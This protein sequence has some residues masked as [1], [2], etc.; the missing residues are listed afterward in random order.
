[1]RGDQRGSESVPCIDNGDGGLKAA[2]RAAK[3]LERAGVPECRGELADPRLDVRIHGFG[4]LRGGRI[5]PVIGGGERYKTIGGRF[6]F[7]LSYPHSAVVGIEA[8]ADKYSGAV[9]RREYEVY[10]RLI[11]VPM[12]YDPEARTYT[13]I[14]DGTFKQA[15]TDNG[16]WVVYDL[17]KDDRFGL[18]GDIAP[19][20]IEQ[21]KWELYAIAVFN[22]AL[23]DN[24]AGSTEPRYRF[25]GVIGRAEAAAKVIAG[26]LSNFRA[27]HYYGAGAITPFQDASEDPVALVGPANVEDGAFEYG[28]ATGHSRRYSAVAVS[29]SDPADGYRLGIELV[30]DDELVAE[31]G[32]R[33]KDVAALYCTHRS[34]AHR[35]GRHILVE[36]EHEAGTLGYTA[37]LDHAS[38]WPGAI[39]RVAD[40]DRVADRTACRVVSLDRVVVRTTETET[41]YRLARSEPSAPGGGRR[42]ANHV[43]AGWQVAEPEPTATESV[44]SVTRTVT[45]EN[46]AFAS[47]TGWGGVTEEASPLL[48]APDTVTSGGALIWSDAASGLGDLS[49]LAVSGS[50]HLTYLEIDNYVRLRTV[51]APGGSDTA[52]GPEL[53]A[54]WESAADAITIQVDG[55]ED[56]VL[57]GPNRAGNLITDATE[58]YFWY[59]SDANVAYTRVVTCFSGTATTTRTRPPRRRC[60]GTFASTPTLR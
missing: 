57:G 1:M 2:Q 8:E 11:D 48:G 55:L 51:A 24:G 28:E 53:Q 14:W 5:R 13:G 40:P 7:S 29:F 19:E 9:H 4:E 16:A 45:Y 35:Y 10:G 6:F 17:L 30:V 32:Y 26:V 34:Q 31:Y 22:D 52:A 43:P 56:I 27:S 54:T 49:F 33:Q 44:W 60:T 37:G 12:N 23:V 20:R 3:L 36:Q 18:G 59:P 15:W 25:T 21:T 39:V 46:E 38:V 47:A 50:A 42:R 41:V 58:P